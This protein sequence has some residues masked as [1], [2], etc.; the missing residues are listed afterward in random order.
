MTKSSISGMY[1]R[2]MIAFLGLV[3][4]TFSCS[5]PPQPIPRST[6][7]IPPTLFPTNTL[8]PTRITATS[9]EENGDWRQLEPGLDFRT[10]TLAGVPAQVLRVDPKALDIRLLYDPDNPRTVA[11]WNEVSGALLTINAGFFEADYTTSGLLFLSGREYGRSYAE[12]EDP[13]YRSSGVLILL[14][15]GASIQV[16]S[17]Q[18]YQASQ[19]TQFALE[20]YPVLI[21]NGARFQFDLIERLANRSAVAVDNEGRLLLILVY[22]KPVTLK[23]FQAGLL[24]LSGELGITSALNLDGGPSSGMVITAVNFQLEK[25]SFSQVPIVLAVFQK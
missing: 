3:V 7:A 9:Q 23:E 14:P 4:L 10:F 5:L 22:D 25:N 21:D 6:A 12:R 20:G 24:E 1:K 16:V 13:R 2:V 15:E 19:E 18:P 17:D 11:G 8:P